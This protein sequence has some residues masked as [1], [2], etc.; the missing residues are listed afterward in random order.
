MDPTLDA[1]MLQLGQEE[2]AE[3]FTKYKTK[4]GDVPSADVEPSA[5]QISAGS[6][7]NALASLWSELGMKVLDVFQV[8]FGSLGICGLD[9]SMY[10]RPPLLIRNANTQGKIDPAG[11]QNSRGTPSTEKASRSASST[12]EAHAETDAHNPSAKT[13][14]RTNAIHA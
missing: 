6:V 7:N 5:D 4:F 9:V 11:M 14:G 12:T 10:G 13:I 8:P 1:E 2:F 3:M